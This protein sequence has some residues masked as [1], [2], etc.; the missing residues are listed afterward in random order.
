MPREGK[1]WFE[2]SLLVC[3][4]TQTWDAVSEP[5][6]TGSRGGSGSEEIITVPTRRTDHRMVGP[7]S[8]QST[9]NLPAKETGP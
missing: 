5:H 9:P 3:S 8:L 2:S 4:R 1:E 6:P 7:Q